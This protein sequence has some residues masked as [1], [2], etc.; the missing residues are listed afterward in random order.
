V[1]GTGFEADYAA[2]VA[3]YRAGRHDVVVERG[4]VLARSH[5]GRAALFN[6]IGASLAGLGRHDEAVE[7]YSNALAIEPES[8]DAVNNLGAALRHL[9]RIEAAVQCHRRALAIRPDHAAAFNNLGTALRELGREDEAITA[10]RRAAEVRPDL[11]EAH[12]NLGNMLVQAGRRE[13][14]V[15]CFDRALRL[16]PGDGYAR[17]QK[18]FLQAHLCDW[19]AIDA[20]AAAIPELGVSVGIVSPFTLMA[21]D[22]SPERHRI[23]AERYVADRFPPPRPRRFAAAAQRPAR[24][25]IGYF[26]ADFHDHATMHLMAGIFERHDRSRFAIHAFSYGPDRD[27]MARRRLR[28]SIDHFEDVRALTDADIAR[29]ARQEQ[30]DIAIDLKGLT[31]DSRPGIFAE[32]SAPLQ[33]GWL[34]YPGTLGAPLLDYL[35]ADP[36]V[37]PDEQRGHYAERIIYL[38]DTYLSSDDRRPIAA[39]PSRRAMGLPEQGFVFGCFNASYKIGADAFAIWMRLLGAV[40]GSVLWLLGDEHHAEQR[41]RR[42]AAGHGI[43]PERLIFADPLPNPEHL[44]RLRLADLF[45]D[46]FVYNAHTTANDALWAGQPLITV[47]GVSFPSRVASSL[48]RAAGLPELIARDREHYEAMALE[49]ALNR[50]KLNGIRDRLSFARLASPLFDTGRF[51]TFLETA[52]DAIDARWRAGEPPADIHIAR[53]QSPWQ[54]M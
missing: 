44:A 20:E 24:L 11:F 5:P 8:A 50:E 17:A 37:I 16:R 23:R 46:C 41:L 12:L 22:D 29:L 54:P 1:T 15:A 10:F 7:A 13:E 39:T 30:V 2:L 42:E 18:L 26:S 33:V 31:Y 53:Q 32:G 47:P 4:G 21:L 38:P 48:L 45:L 43:A 36:W 14:A 6:L 9:G 19:A 25:R 40:E 51:T 35:I 52:Y 28:A 34:G 27:D 49:L 3:L